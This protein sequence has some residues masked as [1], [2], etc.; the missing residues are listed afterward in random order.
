MSSCL[1]FFF[2]ASFCFFLSDIYG[3]EEDE[4]KSRTVPSNNPFIIEAPRLNA[5]K[6]ILDYLSWKWFLDGVEVSVVQAE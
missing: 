3:F 2:F 4:E 6:Q 1:F 5:S